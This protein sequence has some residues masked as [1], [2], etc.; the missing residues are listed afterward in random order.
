MIAPKTLAKKIA[1]ALDRKMGVD[2]ELLD[3]KNISDICNYL[4]FCSARNRYH[5]EALRDEALD[6]IK[7]R[8]API[9]G[10]EGAADS[11]WIVIDTGRL[12]IHLF[13]SNMRDYYDLSR[14]WADGKV[15][16]LP[17]Q[18]EKSNAKKKPG[19][20]NNSD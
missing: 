17:I 10:T 6:E 2:I 18:R 11:G 5:L 20:K 12:I 8:R 16:D 1:S 4:L 15:V 9:L 14:L 13:F 3:V 19:K 7:K